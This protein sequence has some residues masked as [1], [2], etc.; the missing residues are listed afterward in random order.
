LTVIPLFQKKI[1]QEYLEILGD[2]DV[3][4]VRA[5][6]LV[7]IY[8]SVKNRTDH[9]TTILLQLAGNISRDNFGFETEKAKELIVACYADLERLDLECDPTDSTKNYQEH[10][11]FGQ[12]VWFLIP[13]LF[14]LEALEEAR[15]LFRA[16]R[17]KKIRDGLEDK[18]W[19]FQYPA[20][21]R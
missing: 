16:V 20:F 2:Y 10:L 9:V 17:I 12:L 8:H 7:A 18:Y 1:K 11:V 13:L 5:D 19:Q 15:D 4:D 21:D 6:E 14:R 3:D